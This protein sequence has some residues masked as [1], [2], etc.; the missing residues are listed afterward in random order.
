M[1]GLMSDASAEGQAKSMAPLAKAS[2]DAGVPMY[3]GEP[4]IYFDMAV[5][6]VTTMRQ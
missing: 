6:F 4:H 2:N 5:F 3:I 1:P